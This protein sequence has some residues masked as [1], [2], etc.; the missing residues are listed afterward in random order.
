[1]IKHDQKIYAWSC[2]YTNFSGEGSLARIFVK[3]L[4]KYNKR[5]IVKSYLKKQK[6]LSFVD[7]YFSVIIGISFCW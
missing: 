6:K 5:I 2:D 4:K 1:M 7:K 3:D